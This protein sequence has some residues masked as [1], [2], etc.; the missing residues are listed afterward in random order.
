MS[1]GAD[2][3]VGLVLFFLCEGTRSAT[4]TA[5]KQLRTQNCKLKPQMTATH[6]AH[7]LNP[8]YTT[9]QMKCKRLRCGVSFALARASQPR[10][11]PL[12][13]VDSPAT[14]GAAEE[15]IYTAGICVF[16]LCGQGLPPAG[17]VRHE[18]RH[19]SRNPTRSS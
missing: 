11:G 7:L 14:F 17:T 13:R 2:V 4:R 8:A 10:P 15:V 16:M 9:M 5:D 1:S 3:G 18:S 12:A 6:L 19:D